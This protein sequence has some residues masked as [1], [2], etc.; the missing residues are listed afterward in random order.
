M[1]TLLYECQGKNHVTSH[2]AWYLTLVTWG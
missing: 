2:S 1:Y